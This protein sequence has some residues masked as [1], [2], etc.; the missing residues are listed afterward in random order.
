MGLPTNL[1]IEAAENWCVQINCE[2]DAGLFSLNKNLIWIWGSLF[3]VKSQIRSKM[4]Q[5]EGIWTG[6]SH[7]NNVN[8]DALYWKKNG[9]MSFWKHQ[10]LSL[11]IKANALKIFQIHI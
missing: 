4:F 7:L 10:F 8:D 1:Q 6:I 11:M 5:Y 2:T 3:R 9:Q